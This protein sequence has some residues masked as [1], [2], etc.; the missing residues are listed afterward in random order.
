MREF[1]FFVYPHF[2]RRS[3]KL[4]FLFG[5]LN[6]LSTFSPFFNK[7]L[8]QKTLFPPFQPIKSLCLAPSVPFCSLGFFFGGTPPRPPY[9][10]LIF[11]FFFFFRGLYLWAA[12]LLP[13]ILGDWSYV[14]VLVDFFSLF[15]FF[16]GCGFRAY[17]PF[18][19]PFPS[20]SSTP[21]FVVLILFFPAGIRL[22]HPPAPVLRVGRPAPEDPPET[23]NLA[24]PYFTLPHFLPLVQH[25]F[26]LRPS[27]QK[28][29]FRDPFR[30]F[31]LFH[32]LL[33]TCPPCNGFCPQFYC[34]SLTFV[35]C[36][37]HLPTQ[38]YIG[39]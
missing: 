35:G 39:F 15:F 7:S 32:F 17:T 38:N 2:R 13:S 34:P 16:S 11:I 9:H 5:V 12:G 24:F 27:P 4:K 14:F 8:H 3:F 22:Q 25:L 26:K 18:I 33:H 21:P 30:G 19:Y 29:L 37:K 10:F 23:T 28:G 31:F 20:V 6:L 1:L 36:G